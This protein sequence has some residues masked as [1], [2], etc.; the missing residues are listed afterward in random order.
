MYIDGPGNLKF[1]CELVTSRQVNPTASLPFFRSASDILPHLFIFSRT[2]SKAREKNKLE[3]KTSTNGS[4][5]LV[6]IYTVRKVPFLPSVCVFVCYGIHA[7][8]CGIVPNVTQQQFQTNK[9]VVKS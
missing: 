3:L 2:L 1:L 9:P 4:N 7:F 6:E 8:C 5:L